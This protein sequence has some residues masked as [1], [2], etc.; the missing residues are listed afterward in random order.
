LL[1][2]TARQGEE[3]RR[4]P[5]MHPT[6]SGLSHPHCADL[7]DALVTCHETESFVKKWG[8]GVCN[9]P[10]AALDLCF[11]EEKKMKRAANKEKKAAMTARLVHISRRQASGEP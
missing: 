9:A 8:F 3:R 11:R 2:R 4:S 7:I 1:A 6:L 5:T 10:K